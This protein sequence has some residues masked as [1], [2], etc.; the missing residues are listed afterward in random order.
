MKTLLPTSFIPLNI[1]QILGTTCCTRMAKN[2]AH[3]NFSR[4]YLCYDTASILEANMLILWGS[5]S[6]KLAL[7][8]NDY[9]PL[10]PEKNFILHMSGCKKR[11]NNEITFSDLSIIKTNKVIQQ[12]QINNAEI[13]NIILE[14][15]KCLRA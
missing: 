5:I 14:A 6:K 1:Y 8:I 13:K 3:K 12:C 4:H 7:K 2:F 15:K 10:L 11:I 9:L